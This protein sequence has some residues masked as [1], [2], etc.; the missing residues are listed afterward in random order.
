MK[1]IVSHRE[2]KEPLSEQELRIIA[3]VMNLEYCS[4]F[5]KLFQQSPKGTPLLVYMYISNALSSL[6]E[7]LKIFDVIKKILFC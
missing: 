6:Y 7:S 4:V 5:L 1:A 2:S 3:L